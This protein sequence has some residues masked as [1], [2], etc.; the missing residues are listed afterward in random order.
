MTK[1]FTDL[2]EKIKVAVQK[3]VDLEQKKKELIADLKETERK[4]YTM[5]LHEELVM[6]QRLAMDLRAQFDCTVRFDDRDSKCN[7]LKLMFKMNDSNAFI[8]CHHDNLTT[9]LLLRESNGLSQFNSF[10]ESDVRA[11][12]DYLGSEE[13]TMRTLEY[14]RKGYA[15][16]FNQ[17]LTHINKENEGLYSTVEEL[18]KLLADSTVMEEK[19]DGTVE[20]HLGGK[21]F[22][23]EVVE[24]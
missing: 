13:K 16:I 24:E 20:I 8:Q 10:C 5:I 4:N 17:Y 7:G 19:E 1:E 18:T 12:A 23:G 2:T 3:N 14:V 21:T 6:Y 15:E 22:R 11:I 9:Y